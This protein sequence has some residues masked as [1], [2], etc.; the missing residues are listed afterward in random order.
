[1]N[2]HRRDT[3]TETQKT[4]LVLLAGLPHPICGAVAHTIEKSLTPSPRVIFEASGTDNRELYKV[5]TVT[6]LLRAASNY[7]VRQ[8]KASTSAPTPTQILLAYVPATDEERLLAAF[9]FCVFP[10]R[11]TRLAEYDEHGRQYRHNHRTTEGYVVPSLQTALRSFTEVKRRLSSLSWREPLFLPPRNFKVSDKERVAD[12]FMDMRRAKTPW[13]ATLTNLRTT[14]VT[15]EQL[16]KHIEK[17]AH[18]E[19]FSDSR[20]L[21]FPHDLSNH[22]SVRELSPNCSDDDRKQFMRSSFRFGVPLL[23]GYHH[24]VQ[25]AGRRLDGETF[26]CSCEGIVR[27]YCAYANVYP[28]D[29][30]RPSKK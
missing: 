6:G 21:L 29:F 25:Y 2:R 22:G 13:G 4:P 27:L 3:R 19:V 26:E 17:G 15:H 12:I 9:D 10:V 1:M 24:D 16:P 7:A 14:K 20:S 11:L 30:I 28:S 23:D 18:K 5:Q 8:L